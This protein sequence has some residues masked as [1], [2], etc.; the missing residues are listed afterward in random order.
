MKEITL[1]A[2]QKLRKKG[3]FTASNLKVGTMYYIHDT[4]KS[5]NPVYIGK[6]VGPVNYYNDTGV[7]ANYKFDEVQYLVKPSNYRNEPREV[8]SNV[9]K[10]YEVDME[11]TT[12][13]IKHKKTTIKELKSFINETKAEPHDTTP[14]ISFMG[15]DYRKT[16]DKF[17]NKSR[18]SSTKSTNRSKRS[19]PTITSSSPSSSTRKRSK[20]SSSRRTS[21]SR[22]PSSSPRTSY[23]SRTSSSFRRRTRTRR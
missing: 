1:E 16:R 5:S 6:Y 8:F 15:K 14:P 9:E 18:S 4:R 17:Y 23:S 2:F 20:R 11:P 21:S 22:T 3:P 10:Y 7:L 19:T 12:I 13:D